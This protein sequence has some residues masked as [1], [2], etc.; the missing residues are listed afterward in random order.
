MSETN[1]ETPIRYCLYARK[2]TESDERQ[3]MSI[4][5]QIRE[6]QQIAESENAEIISIRQESKSAKQTGKRKEFIELLEDIQEGTVNAIL[7]WSADR[8]SRNAGDLGRLVDLMDTG[9]LKQIRTFGQ[10]F[11]NTPNKK[12]LLMILGSQAK[13]ENDNRSKNITRGL[14][15]KCANG[16]R[17]GNPPI[18]YKLWRDPE[19]Q[20]SKSVVI[21][22]PERA[23]FIKDLFI[24]VGNRLL[25]GRE[26]LAK[27]TELGLRSVRDNKLSIGRV[28]KILSDPFYY[29]EFE[30]PKKSGTW[31]KGLHEPIVQKMHWA[32]ARNQIKSR[33]HKRSWG[34]KNMPWNGLFKCGECGSGVCGSNNINRHGKIYTYYMCTKWGG[35]NSCKAKYIREEKLIEQISNLIAENLA[36]SIDTDS[37]FYA[38]LKLFNQMQESVKPD[39]KPMTLGQYVAHQLKHG[40]VTQKQ[41][42]LKALTGQLYLTKGEVSYQASKV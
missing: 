1:L 2:S 37:D 16:M 29:G 7:T 6:M 15:S 38:Q 40:T 28:Y 36:D 25:S 31:Y 22:D 13:L 24:D 30:Y 20:N 26:A 41:N 34:T 33:Q 32:K 3:A 42:L 17:P 39:S 23:H 8:L 14:Y 19:K 5:A 18:G 27:Q 35:K 12:F 11:D 9:K 10:A 4:E 21:L